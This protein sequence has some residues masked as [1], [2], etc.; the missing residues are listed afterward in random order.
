[1]R[2][3]YRFGWSGIPAAKANFHFFSDGVLFGSL[4]TVGTARL[5]W[6]LDA[7]FTSNL[8][9]RTGLPLHFY[10]REEYR[11]LQRFT[12]IDF[13]PE[14]A[15]VI[16]LEFPEP[17]KPEKTRTLKIPG[18]HDLHSA[19]HHVRSAPL[20]S[21]DSLSMI[22]C[23]GQTA[24][25][26]TVRVGARKTIEVP[27]G[28]RR[29]IRLDLTLGKIEKNGS[30]SAVKKFRRATG[31]MSDDKDRLLLRLEGEVF[32]GKV[33]CELESTDFKEDASR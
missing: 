11:A 18:L 14:K 2:T 28:A 17:K 21:R 10:L 13:F 16:R 12:T 26:A 27:A 9:P 29:A 15:R 7:T 25:L 4:G 23:P 31:W 19:L 8:N 24:Y 6:P 33:Y 32:I 3:A 30:I 5:L 1:M 20:R 22:V